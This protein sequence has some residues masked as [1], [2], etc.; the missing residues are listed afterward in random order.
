MTHPTSRPG[1]ARARG[2]APVAPG[3]PAVLLAL[4]L[5]ACGA[6]A[7]DEAAAPAP[8]P[9]PAASSAAAAATEAAP[10]TNP[11]GGDAMFFKQK[12]DGLLAVGSPAPEFSVPDQDGTVR[13]LSEFKGRRVLL[14]FYPKADTPG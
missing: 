4:A 13:T 11:A 5:A 10:D 3:A 1:T 14:W 9:G 7:P 12:D 2:Q 8:A 6:P